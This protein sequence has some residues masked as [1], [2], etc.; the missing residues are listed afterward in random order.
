MD[1][2]AFEALKDFRLYEGWLHDDARADVEKRL[3]GYK[4]GTL[5][6]FHEMLRFRK[7]AGKVQK[8]ILNAQQRQVILGWNG[9][10]L[11]CSLHRGKLTLEWINQHF[12]FG[13]AS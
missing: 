8:G 2:A 9:W 1:R 11:L 10:R 6:D 13:F 3:H 4:T 12:D 7:Q 5:I